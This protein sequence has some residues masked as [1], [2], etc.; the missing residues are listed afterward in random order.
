MDLPHI[1]KYTTFLVF[2]Y[3]YFERENT[4]QYKNSEM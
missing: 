4:Q 2:L 3:I 1:F